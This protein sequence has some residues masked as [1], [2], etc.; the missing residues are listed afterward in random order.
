VVL[1]DADMRRPRQ[2]HVFRLG[3]PFGLS[4]AILDTKLD[5]SAYG[6]KL[7]HDRLSR[8]FAEG[9]V[10]KT[11]EH[12][13]AASI[14]DLHVVTSG[15]IPPNPADLLG[16]GRMEALI[17]RLKEKADMVILD[18]PPVMAVT[19]AV[20]LATRVDGVLLVNDARR[21][22]RAMVQRTVERLR[23][24][25]APLLGVVL[26]SV[27]L[28]GSGYYAY[29]YYYGHNE[30]ERRTKRRSRSRRT[31]PAPKLTF[32][33]RLKRSENGRAPAQRQHVSDRD[34]VEKQE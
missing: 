27:S 9:D 22:R 15:P 17:A 4:N 13:S 25:D 3:N 11:V 7:T 8:L 29:Q 6:W 33:G 16:S 5:L 10:E 31:W 26:N 30:E 2:H 21:T 24:V 19:D 32:L 12:G 20:V 34:L 14:G 23:Q 28:G 18:T 1:V